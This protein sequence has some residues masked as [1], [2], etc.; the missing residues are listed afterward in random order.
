MESST[1]ITQ[2]QKA[3]AKPANTNAPGY[4]TDEIDLLELWDAIWHRFWLVLLAG[5]LA[6]DIAFAVTRILITPQYT[7][8]STM[9]VITKETTL[10][11][12]ADLQ[13]GSKLTE[14]YGILI[15]SRPVLQ[16]TIEEV[17]LD[18]SYKAL[19][20][21]ISIE[22]PNDSR[23]LIISVE[24]PDP[25]LAKLV[26]DTLAQISSDYIADKME[27]TAPKIIEEG[28]SPMN[29]SSPSLLRNVAIGGMLGVLAACFLICMGVILN[30]SVQTE[31]DIERYLE[32]PVLAVI[33]E[34]KGDGKDTGRK[35]RSRKKE[36]SNKNK[37]NAS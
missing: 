26:V 13:L 16:Q 14:D 29:P 22:T 23:M 6:A 20:K 28:E 37:Q 2:V 1:Q 8:S 32:I 9:L 7:S 12:L 21:K 18:M 34:K 3:P 11:S 25:D 10:A 24:Q 35:K 27:V 5:F 30:D 15:T 19:R 31:D 4:N 33:P 36:H 17:G